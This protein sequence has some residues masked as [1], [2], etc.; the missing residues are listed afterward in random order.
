[1]IVSALQALERVGNDGDR[2]TIGGRRFLEKRGHGNAFA[3]A[4][5]VRFCG[6]QALIL[7]CTVR[8]SARTRPRIM[9]SYFL[10]ENA[11]HGP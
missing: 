7:V 11:C 6:S 4:G 2:T 10:E 3:D 5:P 1:M 9:G 8:H